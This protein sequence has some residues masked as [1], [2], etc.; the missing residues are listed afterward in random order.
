MKKILLVC[1]A[2]MST[3]LLV[4]KMKQAAKEMGIEV[5]IEALP[6]SECSSVIDEVDIVLLG[7]QVRFQKPQVD[8]LVDGRIPVEVMDMRLYGTMNGKA[9]LESTLSKI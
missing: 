6:V 8:K 1:A 5:D 4:N 9:I 3:S 2:G 7:P